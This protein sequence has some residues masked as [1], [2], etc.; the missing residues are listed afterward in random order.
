MILMIIGRGM[1]G[2]K[3]D[4]RDTWADNKAKSAVVGI[5][6]KGLDRLQRHYR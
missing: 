5:M 1:S 2:G 6:G 4:S 3:L